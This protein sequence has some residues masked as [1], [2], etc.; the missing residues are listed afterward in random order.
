MA[1]ERLRGGAASRG[2]LTITDVNVSPDLKNAHVFYSFL[3]SEREKKLAEADL[4]KVTPLLRGAIKKRLS[5]KI[6]P[7]LVF[8]FDDTSRR[9]SRIDDILHKLGRGMG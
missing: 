8:V 5:I 3:G 4:R 2:L 9:A 1:L 7:N 6:I